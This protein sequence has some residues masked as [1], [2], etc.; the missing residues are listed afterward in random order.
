MNDCTKGEHANHYTTD[1]VAV[2]LLCFERNIAF[3]YNA[4]IIAFLYNAKNIACL[5]FVML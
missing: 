3:L 2:I 1:V 5:Y 4:K